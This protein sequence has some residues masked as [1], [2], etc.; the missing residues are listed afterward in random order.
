MKLD[1]KCFYAK[2][3]VLSVKEFKL[4]Q[5][6]TKRKY[7]FK[8]SFWDRKSKFLTILKIQGSSDLHL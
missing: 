1:S 6:G 8:L 2:Q 4:S 3:N 5:K 7:K